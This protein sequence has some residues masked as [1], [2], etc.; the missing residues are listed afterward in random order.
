MKHFGACFEMLVRAHEQRL[1]YSCL[2][3]LT[4]I[5]CHMTTGV[6]VWARSFENWQ[7]CEQFCFQRIA[8]T[9]LLMCCCRRFHK[10]Q[11]AT[12]IQTNLTNAFFFSLLK[13]NDHVKW[14]RFRERL[15]E[16]RQKPPLQWRSPTTTC[17][18]GV[19]PSTLGDVLTSPR[20]N[21]NDLTAAQLKMLAHLCL[22]AMHARTCKTCGTER[23]LAVA[24][25]DKKWAVSDDQRPPTSP[26]M[27]TKRARPPTPVNSGCVVWPPSKPPRPVLWLRVWACRLDGPLTPTLC[28]LRAAF[29]QTMVVQIQVKVSCKGRWSSPAPL[30]HDKFEPQHSPMQTPVDP[31]HLRR[32]TRSVMAKSVKE[33]ATTANAHCQRNWETESVEQ[34]SAEDRRVQLRETTC[35]Q[36]KERSCSKRTSLQS[37]HCLAHFCWS[38]FVP[39]F[40][41]HFA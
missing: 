10:Q 9:Q 18:D 32:H 25:L 15:P 27:T 2:L 4:P 13:M 31:T 28:Q 35:R 6:L 30:L 20:D 11:L 7:L 12:S 23:A 3:G 36:R 34:K 21:A 24:K 22:Q 5:S 14:W 38:M 17:T 19:S 29:R 8:T 37:Q 39:A 41:L 26:A 40:L 1:C 33:T 16:T